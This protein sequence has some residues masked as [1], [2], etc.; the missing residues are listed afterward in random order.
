MQ[1][2]NLRYP[3][4][5]LCQA[6]SHAG[7]PPIDSTSEANLSEQF[8][9]VKIISLNSQQTPTFARKLGACPAP[10]GSTVQFGTR[11]GVDKIVA[12]VIAVVKVKRPP[13]RPG[14]ARADVVGV[15]ACTAYSP[16]LAGVTVGRAGAA[17]TD[18]LSVRSRGRRRLAR[19]DGGVSHQAGGVWDET[20]RNHRGGAPGRGAGPDAPALPRPGRPAAGRPAGQRPGPVAPPTCPGADGAGPR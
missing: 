1:E 15:C 8:A 20:V 17:D 13:P 10:A 16:T 14:L 5:A 9:G 7:D 12:H 11:G 6:R 19:G 2:S 18:H 3:L 4:E